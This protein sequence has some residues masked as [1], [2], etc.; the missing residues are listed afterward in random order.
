MAVN[1][2]AF[3]NATL[4]AQ[5][6]SGIVLVNPQKNQ[7]IQPMN[8]PNTSSPGSILPEKFLFHIE[9]QNEIRLESDITDHFSES[10][11]ALQN[12]IALRPEEYT[13]SGFIGELNNVPPQIL[14]EL[15]LAADKL[16]LL[17]AYEPEISSAAQQAYDTAFQAYQLT[18]ALI[19]NA[20]DLWG[21]ADTSNLVNGDESVTDV[22]GRQNKQQLAF[23]KFYGY[24]RNRTL[25]TVQ[26]PWAIFK[27]MV[28]KT[29]KATQDDETR[30]I[31]SFEI[32]F[33]RMRFAETVAV[34][35]ANTFGF[36]DTSSQGRRAIQDQSLVDKG[37]VATGAPTDWV[38]S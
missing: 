17:S 38:V 18:D 19:N 34:S 31:T 2:E 1:L 5:T 16:S 37:S 13:V 20:V 23:Q 6:L 21:P 7:G 30:M 8:N 28:I 29:L 9:A 36:F 10:N 3:S 4:T 26:T 32:T 35:V 33:K 15:K 12:Q 25:F 11:E 22:G 14:S 27:N 24:W